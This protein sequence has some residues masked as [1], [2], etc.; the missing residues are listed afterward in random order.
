MEHVLKKLTVQLTESIKHGN[1]ITLVEKDV[2]IM[3]EQNDKR[4]ET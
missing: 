4:H 1:R 3:K 2:V